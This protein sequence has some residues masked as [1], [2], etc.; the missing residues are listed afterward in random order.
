M[1]QELMPLLSPKCHISGQGK[2]I[3]NHHEAHITLDLLTI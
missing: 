2:E 3:V 1:T